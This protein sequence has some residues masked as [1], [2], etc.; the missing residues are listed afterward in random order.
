MLKLLILCMAIAAASGTC[1]KC[2]KAVDD[3]V[4]GA[5]TKVVELQTSIATTPTPGNP[6]ANT[7]HKYVIF[8][9]G[10]ASKLT[11]ANVDALKG[12]CASPVD[13]PSFFRNIKHELL[14]SGG[15][16]CDDFLNF[17]YK[18]GTVR[19]DGEWAPNPYSCEDSGQELSKS[20]SSLVGLIK[21]FRRKHGD[22]EFFIV[23]HS[24]GGVVIMNAMSSVNSGDI[25][26]GVVRAVVTMDSPLNHVTKSNLDHLKAV[27]FGTGVVASL[28]DCN[29]KL[30]LSSKAA[31][32]L[33]DVN[34]GNRESTR[35]QL[36]SKVSVLESLGVSVLTIG[37]AQDCLWYLSNCNYLPGEWVD[38][39]SSQVVRTASVARLF[40]LGTNGCSHYAPCVGDS[41]T[42]VA[43][44]ATT[45]SLVAS[46]IEE[47]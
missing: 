3:A 17:S 30:L 36:A 1:E 26:P 22:A 43:T 4:S 19:Q 2:G 35:A 45:V 29:F 23:G 27:W 16:V 5:K 42:L 7:G 21:D 8:V 15:F 28:L 24:L 25:K 32:E 14:G 40:D 39:T 44:D 10:I 11:S 33:A 37:N 12:G 9:E 6:P 34:D 38:D 18:G 47:R 31:G 46:A 41:H 20:T 13:D